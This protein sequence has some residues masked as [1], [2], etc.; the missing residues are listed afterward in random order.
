MGRSI[1]GKQALGMV[2][3]FQAQGN[4][5]AMSQVGQGYMVYFEN[6]EFNLIEAEG[7]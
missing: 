7:S 3:A 1:L 2:S 5:Y 4:T 6:I